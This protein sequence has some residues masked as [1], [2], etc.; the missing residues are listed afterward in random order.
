MVN[1]PKGG[2]PTKGT[3][4][5]TPFTATDCARFHRRDFLKV[6][7]AG[8]LGLSLPH[9]LRLE[10]RAG[11]ERKRRARNVIM[12]WLA[13]GP[14]TIDMWDPK[15]QAPDNIRGDFKAI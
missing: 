9:V 1:P 15:P 7:T 3:T 12:I 8:L 4:L 13:G 5:M 2:T 10:A 6:G 14:S 11:T